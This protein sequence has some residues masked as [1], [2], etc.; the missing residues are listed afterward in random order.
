MLFGGGEH[1]TSRATTFPFVLLF[2]ESRPERLIDGKNKKA[3][4]IG[5]DVWI[6]L[7]ATIMSGVIKLEKCRKIINKK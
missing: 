3:T 6:G 1:I 4:V 7:G 5:H 2:A